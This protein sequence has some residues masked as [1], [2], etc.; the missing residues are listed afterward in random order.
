VVPVGPA[1]NKVFFCFTKVDVGHIGGVGAVLYFG[2][3]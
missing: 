3:R 2:F 1:K